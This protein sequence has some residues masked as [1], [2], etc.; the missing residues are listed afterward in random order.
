VISYSN[1]DIFTTTLNRSIAA[2]VQLIINNI[3]APMHPLACLCIY[4]YILRLNIFV[5]PSIEEDVI[6]R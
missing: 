3:H 4:V 1:N 2:Y 6:K 5:F